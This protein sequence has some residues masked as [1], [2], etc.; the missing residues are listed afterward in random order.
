MDKGLIGG[1]ANRGLVYDWEAPGCE[2]VSQIKREISN[3]VKSHNEEHLIKHVLAI[4][5]DMLKK[6]LLY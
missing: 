4:R 2:G 1:E 3:Q 6:T 5:V